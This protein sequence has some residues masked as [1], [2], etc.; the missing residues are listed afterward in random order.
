MGGRGLGRSATGTCQRK[1]RESNPQGSSLVRVRAGCRRPSACPSVSVGTAGFE[2]AFSCVRGTR[3]LQA[4][5]RPEMLATVQVAQAVQQARLPFRHRGKESESPW[6]ES[7]PHAVAGTRFTADL[8]VCFC[9]RVRSPE[10]PAGVEP[11]HPPW[12]GS[13]QPLH[14]G[15]LKASPSCQRAERVRRRSNPRLQLFRLALSRLSYRPK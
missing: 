5:P 2:P 12:Q 10:H 3:P 9:R 8:F 6:R 7:N 13:R 1:E 14:H 15:C 11:A 4:G